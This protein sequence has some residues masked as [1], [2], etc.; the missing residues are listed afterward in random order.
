VQDV[1][2]DDLKAAY[3][4]GKNTGRTVASGYGIVIGTI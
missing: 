2:A 4:T 3:F 1:N